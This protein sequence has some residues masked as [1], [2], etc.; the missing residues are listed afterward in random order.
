MKNVPSIIKSDSKNNSASNM[1]IVNADDEIQG[2]K[3]MQKED[4]NNF[5]LSGIKLRDLF[6]LEV[7]DNV[8]TE[9]ACKPKCEYSKIT[10]SR[11]QTVY[12]LP[13]TRQ[14]V[15]KKIIRS[16]HDAWRR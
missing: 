5:D 11:T 3:I 12:I 4:M 6:E 13:N 8:S 15:H 1:I 14:R 7:V 16:R 9:S 2:D 10:F